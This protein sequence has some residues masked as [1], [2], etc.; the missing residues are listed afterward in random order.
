MLAN[1]LQLYRYDFSALRGYELT[2]HGTFV[3]RF[4]D[5][6]FLE[7]ERSAWLVHHEGQ[8]AG[9]VLARSFSDGSSEMAEFF[10]VRGHRRRGVG[11]QAAHTAF[12]SRPGRWVVAYDIGNTDAA[13]FWPR[14]ADSVATGPIERRHEGPP[15]RTYEQIVLRFTVT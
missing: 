13:A 5:H 6:Y 8:L 15:R 2:P 7:P 1:L 11:R 3:Y 12:F 4:L 9:F 14:V 10:V